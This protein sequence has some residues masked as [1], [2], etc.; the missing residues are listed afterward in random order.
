MDI[1]RLSNIHRICIAR[2]YSGYAHA[3]MCSEA[4]W[5]MLLNSRGYAGKLRVAS[6]LAERNKQALAVENEITPCFRCESKL[7]LVPGV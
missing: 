1:R 5:S 3:S 4:E 6:V 7:L 2:G